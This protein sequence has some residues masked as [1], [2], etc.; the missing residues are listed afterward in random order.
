MGEWL[1]KKVKN[2]LWVSRFQ[3]ISRSWF[4]QVDPTYELMRLPE[5]FTI[6]GIQIVIAE[7]LEK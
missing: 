3:L 6:P 7:F 5:T 4:Y 1:A 2:E